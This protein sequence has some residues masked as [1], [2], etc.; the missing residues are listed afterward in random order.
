M[1][2]Q[3]VNSAEKITA[4]PQWYNTAPV[5]RGW[6]LALGSVIILILAVAALAAAAAYRVSSGNGQG[7]LRAFGVESRLKSG[8]LGG[9][10]QSSSS[11]PN[12]ETRK[13][14]VITAVSGDSFTLAGN[15]TTTQV[16]TSSSTQYRGGN[17]VK[18][19]DTV[20]VR[21]TIS[22]DTMAASRISIIP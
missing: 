8:E 22:N 13:T 19:D 2:R 10:S 1:A 16:T 21:G 12:G 5:R 3:T 6:W 11:A 14:G 15:G 7:P 9:L 4:G 17:Q 18:V 20:V